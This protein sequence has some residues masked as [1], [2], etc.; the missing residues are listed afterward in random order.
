MLPPPQIRYAVIPP[1]G[2][3]PAV[4]EPLQAWTVPAGGAGNA[5]TVVVALPVATPAAGACTWL[6][7]T[8]A[9]STSPPVGTRLDADGPPLAAGGLAKNP[10]AAPIAL[11]KTQPPASPR[12]SVSPVVAATH[13]TDWRSGVFRRS[14]CKPATLLDS[15]ATSLFALWHAVASPLGPQLADTAC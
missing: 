6:A 4:I 7:Y 9:R 8:F 15:C 1:S 2:T 3:V 14:R 5:P 13:P 11:P 12:T 10:R